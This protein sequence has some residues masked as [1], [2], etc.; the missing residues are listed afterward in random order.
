METRRGGKYIGISDWI[1]HLENE[2][3]IPN[4][5]SI[6]GWSRS[7]LDSMAYV[8]ERSDAARVLEIRMQIICMLFNIPYMHPHVCV[9]VT[10]IWGGWNPSD[11]TANIPAIRVPYYSLHN[12]SNLRLQLTAAMNIL[13][14]GLIDK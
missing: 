9:W 3:E 8:R 10:G 7:Q 5:S 13:I 11:G 14:A 2:T 4:R 12:M 6:S 1:S